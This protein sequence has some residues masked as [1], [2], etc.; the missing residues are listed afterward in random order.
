MMR[1]KLPLLAELTPQRPHL[2]QRLLPLDRLL[3]QDPQPLR[4][5]R[6][7]QVVVGAVLDRFD[8]ALDGPLRRQ[9]DEGEVRQLVLQ[10]LQQFEAAHARHHEVAT[11]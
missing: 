11:R 4:I 1:P 6:L 5:D 10:R 2:A 7:A 9:Q 3:Q 8:R